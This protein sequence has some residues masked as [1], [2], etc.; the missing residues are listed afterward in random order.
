MSTKSSTVHSLCISV[1]SKAL[2]LL[3]L[4]AETLVST[5]GNF[6]FKRMKL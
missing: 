5:K 2:K 4:A 3:F 1:V 6:G